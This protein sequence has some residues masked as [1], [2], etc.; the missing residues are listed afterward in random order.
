MLSCLTRK[1]T[2]LSQVLSHHLTMIPVA[3]GAGNIPRSETKSEFAFQASEEMHLRTF[4]GWCCWRLQRLH[5]QLLFL[6]VLGIKHKFWER[7]LPLGPW[8]FLYSVSLSHPQEGFE[9]MI[10]LPQSL[11]ELGF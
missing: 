9:L 10:L 7:S 2:A 6:S 1:T 3:W 5:I 4:G 8:P 11:R